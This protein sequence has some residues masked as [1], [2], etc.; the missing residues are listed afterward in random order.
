MK[1]YKLRLEQERREKNI[2]LSYNIE[3]PDYRPDEYREPVIMGA[4]LS[5]PSKHPMGQMITAKVLNAMHI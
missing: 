2:R 3:L 5:P 4:P 1:K